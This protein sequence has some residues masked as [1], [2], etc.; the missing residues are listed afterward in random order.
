MDLGSET[1]LVSQLIL[2]YDGHTAATK[3][4]ALTLFYDEV[5]RNDQASAERVGHRA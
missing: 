1:F 3:R 4:L 5:G 2:V